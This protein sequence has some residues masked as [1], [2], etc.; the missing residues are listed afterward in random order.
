MPGLIGK[1]IGMTSVFDEQGRTIPC[2][3][4]E[5][6]P[7]IVTQIK[8]EETDGYRAVQLA[9]DEKKE[10]HTTKA[11]IGHFQKAKTTPKRKVIELKGFVRDWKPGD[12][13]TVDYFH[14]DTWLDVSGI[15]KGKGFQ[16]VIKRHNFRGVGDSSHG[17]HNRQRAPGSIGASSYPSRV[18]R[19]MRMGGRTG[20]TKNKQI[21][22]RVVKIIPEENLLLLKGSVPG[23]KGSYLIIE[24]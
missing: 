20:G 11:M 18:L 5:V 9:F 24:K 10:K 6:G 21:N 12:V 4:I 7:C 22:L 13:I 1:K 19:G 16:G 2:T 23:S 3:V 8:T 15:T 14:D 17:Q